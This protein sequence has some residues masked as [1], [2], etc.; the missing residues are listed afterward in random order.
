[1]VLGTSACTS[2]SKRRS[3][4]GGRRRKGGR[5][6]HCAAVVGHAEDILPRAVPQRAIR[7]AV[8]TNQPVGTIGDVADKR[9]AADV[10]VWVRVRVEKIQIAVECKVADEQASKVTEEE[11][12]LVAAR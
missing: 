4:A 7:S 10:G 2:G 5:R 9:I 3:L 8:D 11:D 6:E 12:A 1:M